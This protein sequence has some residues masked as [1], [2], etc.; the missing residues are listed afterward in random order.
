MKLDR[1]LQKLGIYEYDDIESQKLYDVIHDKIE[2]SIVAHVIDEGQL[3]R[4][5]YT[6]KDLG[7][8]ATAEIYQERDNGIGSE[9]IQRAIDKVG[10]RANKFSSKESK[11]IEFIK[12][13]MSTGFYG[14]LRLR[15]WLGVP[16]E[17]FTVR[18][19]YAGYLPRIPLLV[20]PG[21][22]IKIR[23][24]TYTITSTISLKDN[25]KFC[26]NGW[27]TILKGGWAG[28][29]DVYVP[30]NAILEN[31]D[32]TNGNNNI[33][34]C[35]IKVDA[36][37]NNAASLNLQK[38][39]GFKITGC[40][41]TNPT[42]T[43]KGAVHLR[44][45]DGIFSNNY[46]YQCWI[47]N[48]V[49]SCNYVVAERNVI[50][51]NYDSCICVGTAGNNNLHDVVIANN[52]LKKRT[53]LD[54]GFCVDVSGDIKHVVVAANTCV[55]GLFENIIVQPAEG[56]YPS[57]VIISH[58]TCFDAG[59]HGIQISAVNNAIVKGNR[60]FNPTQHGMF[61]NVDWCNISGNIIN[62]IPDTFWATYVYTDSTTK[63]NYI[64]IS[65]NLCES[66]GIYSSADYSNIVGNT[67]ISS[68]LSGIAL[69]GVNYAEVVSNII[70]N[71]GQYGSTTWNDGITLRDSPYRLNSNYCKIMNNLILDSQAITTIDVGINEI[72]GNNNTIS[73]N[74]LFGSYS[75]SP[76]SKS[77]NNTI[78]ENN[79]GY[80][81]VGNF[82]AP[83]L[84]AS[85]TALTNT[86][87]YPCLMSVYGGT[88]S[89]IAIDG[90]ST[91]HTSGTFVLAP[92]ESITITYDDVTPDPPSWVWYGL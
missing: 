25:I 15:K 57:D 69:G 9:E 79:I 16:L 43:S 31:S 11:A 59:R 50:V 29:W 24:G 66:G 65:N 6:D 7:L 74:S 78:I 75:T 71:S 54:D 86:Y 2:Q 76:I 13:C 68:N 91:G 82:T 5:N 39:D 70:I 10:K 47:L 45:L 51:D 85:G 36:D 1:E 37:D 87:G 67:I 62:S 49:D 81:P 38:V 21:G 34:I 8:K 28:A 3:E 52:I 33:I 27:A 18:T 20:N 23:E 32:F 61:I 53:G 56:Y 89:D 77:G 35:D 55:G 92:S 90:V 19:W 12:A 83:S 17:S 44:A 14:Y 80:N 88:V 72:F 84:P 73:G 22:E 64:S 46:L 26:G 41:F 42:I 48:V 30:G 58:N 63:G 40:Y 4:A 60:I